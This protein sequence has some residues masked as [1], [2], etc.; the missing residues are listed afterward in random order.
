VTTTA[1]LTDLYELTM[2]QATLR[3][4]IAEHPTCFELF[5]RRLPRGRRYGVVAGTGRLGEAIARFRFDDDD[6]AYLRSLGVLD[7]DTLAWLADYRFSGTVEAYREGELYFP[8]SPVV[9]ARGTFAETVVLETLVLSIFNH[10]SAVASAAA[11]MH[12]VAADRLL[13]EMGTR[14]TH[15]QAAIE[16]AR[17]AYLVGFG[18]TSNLAAG[19]SYGIPVYGTAAHAYVLAHP[20]ERSAFEAQIDALGIQT[21]L[22]VDT[23]DITAGIDEAIA[24]GGSRGG[25]PGAVRI[26]SGDLGL[27]ARKARVQLDDAGC[28]ATK[29]VASGDLDEYAIAELAPAPVDA[30]GVGTSVVTGS[31]A[32]TANMIYKLVAAADGP[33]REPQPVAKTSIGKATVGGRKAAYRRLDG[34]GHATEEILLLDGA[35]P[36]P[37]ARALHVPVYDRGEVAYR[38]DLEADRAFHARARAE[39]PPGARRLDAGEPWL[40]ASI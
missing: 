40:V 23:Y 35:T 37:D 26:D 27:E 5:A 30:Y 13:I 18:G 24:A 11:R 39:L 10:A 8:G 21:T 4:G 1:L 15:E 9:S 19:R 32:P 7:E 17:A 29:I 31:G 22:L 16:A 34:D 25:S 36:P 12:E 3:S 33:D 28:D 38:F 2:V 6:L 14:R 20:D